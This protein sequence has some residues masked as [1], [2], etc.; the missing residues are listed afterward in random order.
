MRV[1]IIGN[2]LAGTISSKT[3][4]ELDQKLEIDVF[5]E[6]K[7]H[8]Y[9]RPNLIEFVAGN[10]PQERIFA[11]PGNW[12]QRQKISIHLENPVKRILASFQEVEVGEGKREKYDF[13]LIANGSS[14]FVPPI[15]GA[16]KAGVF[17]L[18]TLD[19]A[20]HILEYLE[21][22]RQVAVIGGGLLGLEI[23]RAIRAKGADVEV[24]EFFDRLLPRQLDVQGASLLK[25]QIEKM[26][27]KIRLKSATE[28]ILGQKEVKGLRF[29]DGTQVKR[30]MV[31][32]A[33]GVRPN[34]SLAKEASLETDRGLIV[35]EYLQAS[36]PKIF[37][38]GDCIQHSGRVYGIIPASF[39]QARIAASN[40]IGEQ[41]KYRGTVPSN[42]LKIVGLYVTSVGL[43]NP[44]GEEFEEIQIENKEDGIYKK[45]VLHNGNLVGAIWI[46]TKK[47]VT[48][49][50]R[51]V[52]EKQN[53]AKWKESLL[54]DNFDFSL[55]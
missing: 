4:R 41:R 55:L 14:A 7:H 44:E 34:T 3:L 29:K 31:V 30:D 43:V 24:I 17:T 32:V 11:F 12:H 20:F 18:R 5:A 53:V 10:I 39:D 33:A 22:H 48:E 38:A 21:N 28:E 52:T 6:E 9:P 37:A 50:S 8:Y 27:I 35:N 54:E 19:D 16:E 47:G 2:G 1:I 49:I 36:H 25:A 40:I 46:G 26:K 13:L 42:T 51:A 15:K 45:I 23:A